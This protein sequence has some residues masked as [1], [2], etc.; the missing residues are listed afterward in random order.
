MLDFSTIWNAAGAE[1]NTKAEVFNGISVS[2]D[3]D[4]LY[5]TGKWWS[6]MFKIKLLPELP[7]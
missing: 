1:K 2:N 6:K 4:V 3:P 5:V 7:S